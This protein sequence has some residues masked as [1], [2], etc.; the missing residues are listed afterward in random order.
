MDKVF[1]IL[2][3][4]KLLGFDA[5]TWLRK[6]AKSKTMLFAVLI[7]VFG[8]IEATLGMFQGVL[9]NYYP[10]IVSGIGIIMGLLRMATTESISNKPL[11]TDAK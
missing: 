1:A 3:T 9:G 4:A 7:T 8:T 5:L 6:A 11:D 10:H 2:E